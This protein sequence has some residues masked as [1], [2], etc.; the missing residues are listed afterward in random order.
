MVEF[1]SLANFWHNAKIASEQS[2]QPVPIQPEPQLYRTFTVLTDS[3][4]AAKE[5]GLI[6]ELSYFNFCNRVDEAR[7]ETKN[8][9]AFECLPQ[10]QL[11]RKTEL[12]ADGLQISLISEVFPIAAEG[13]K[14][15]G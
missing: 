8:T 3:T 7:F 1:S 13:K 5:A 15:N 9:I 14:N 10:E 6:S 11:F 12:I 2:L 4:F